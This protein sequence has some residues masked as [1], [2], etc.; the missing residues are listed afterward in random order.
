MNIRTVNINRPSIS[1]E[2]ESINTVKPYLL[3]IYSPKEILLYGAFFLTF[4][5]VRRTYLSNTIHTSMYAHD[6]N[7]RASS[8]GLINGNGRFGIIEIYIDEPLYYGE[9]T[10]QL[11]E[12]DTLHQTQQE[13]KQKV[14]QQESKIKLL[15][16]Y[17]K[18]LYFA[19]GMPGFLRAKESFERNNIDLDLV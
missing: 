3:Y 13:L 6:S 12:L 1:V 15:E 17:I 18:E 16:E 10:I 9:Y 4:S 8:M 7:I 14:E 11:I 2:F 5:S 19:P